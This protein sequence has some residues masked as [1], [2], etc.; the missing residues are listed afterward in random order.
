M[1]NCKKLSTY[2]KVRPLS[3]SDGLVVLALYKSNPY[4]FKHCPPQPTLSSVLNDMRKLPPAISSEQKQFLG[5]F[6][7]EKLVAVL[8]LVEGYPDSQTVF[9][10]LFM[11]DG[12][13]H[14]KGIGS[15]L[16]QEVI[17]VLTQDFARLRLG[18]VA[19][20]AIAEAFWRKQGFVP[21]GEVAKTD[22]YDIILA[23]FLRDKG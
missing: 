17:Q 11:L 21:T 8:D 23:D 20:N 13:Y 9:I 1:V 19:T 14:G 7:E 6:L 12:D 5:Y 3:E 15:Q 4:F 2:Y 10:G 18:Y 16:F 22:H